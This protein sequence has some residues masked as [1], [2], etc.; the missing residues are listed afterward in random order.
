YSPYQPVPIADTVPYDTLVY[1][2][3]HPELFP[4]V[5][6]VR[7][8]VR[9]YVNF[10]SD[11]AT[12][13]GAHLLGYVGAVNGT[14]QK[15][16][17]GEHYGVDDVIGKAGAEQ[18]FESE[19]R[20]TPRVQRLEVDSRGRLARV[21]S[22][23]PSS[24]GNDVQLSVDVNIQRIAEDSLRQGIENVRTYRDFSIK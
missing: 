13:L 21:V 3:E 17:K 12:P 14:E 5:D 23:T 22:D 18:I 11:G 20:G 19:L 24:A 1:L 15:L 9:Q 8:S 2:K 4:H 16:H 10:A 7:R 6:V